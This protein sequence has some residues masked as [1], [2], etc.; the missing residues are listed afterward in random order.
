MFH[1]STSTLCCLFIE[2]KTSEENYHRMEIA[3]EEQV[4]SYFK[5]RQQLDALG[6][7]L[8]SYILKPVYLLPFLQPGRLLKVLKFYFLYVL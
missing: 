5:I 1:V 8:R 4:A 2:L 7:E 3:D 6:Q